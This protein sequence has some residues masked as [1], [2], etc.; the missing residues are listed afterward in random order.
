M[1]P[2]LRQPRRRKQRSR[3]FG[4]AAFL[5]ICAAA[6]FSMSIFFR[7][8]TVEIQ[9]ESRYSDEEIQDAAGIEKGSN[10]FFINTF[11]AGNRILSK[12]SYIESAAITRHPPGRVV[13]EIVESRPLAYVTIDSECWLIDRHCKLLEKTTTAGA[14]PYIRVLALTPIAPMV[15]EIIAPGEAEMPK[16]TYLAELLS[17]LEAWNMTKDV[18]EIDTGNV[19]NP[20]FRYQGRFT[21]RMGGKEEVSYKLELL[22]SAVS[23]LAAGDSGTLD[24]SVDKRVSFSPD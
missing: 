23:Q 19:A 8:S 9:G 6:V 22:L 18:S 3:L 7:V 11:S 13:I 16:V 14:A 24:L 21:V 20:S 17:G 1:A 5:I 10:L 2:E 4:P 15:G 12:L